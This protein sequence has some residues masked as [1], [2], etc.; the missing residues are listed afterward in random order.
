MEYRSATTAARSEKNLKRAEE[1]GL[2]ALEA[3]ECSPANNSLAPYFLATEVYLQQKNYVK[4]AEM[5]NIAEQ[6]NPNQPL[7]TPFKLG[8]TPVQTIGEGVEAF[9]DQEWTKIYNNAVDLI[10]REK[11]E[12]AKHKIET[13]IL[14]HPQKGENYKTLAAMYIQEEN[15]DMAL[16]TADRGLEEDPKNSMLY[17]MKADILVQSDFSGIP[18]IDEKLKKELILLFKSAKDGNDIANY[19]LI[20]NYNLDITNY[21]LE[22]FKLKLNTISEKNQKQSP[23][24]VKMEN[25]KELYLKAIEFSD[26]PGPIMRKLLFVY[27]DMGDNQKA[28]DYSNELLDKYPN[29]ADLYYNVGV[30]YQR[31]TLELFDPARKLFLETTPESEPATIKGVYD[32][33]KTTRQYAYNSKDYFLQASD[34]ELDKNLSTHEAV[35]EM[36]KLMDQ[37]DEIFIPSIR[38]TAHS[39]GIELN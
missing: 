38:E 8:D 18:V 1:W 23:D 9:R 7:E 10:Q 21:S 12:D 27:I 20:K 35:S 3:P 5:L 15:M 32:S 33:F 26:N 24:L 13:A 30:L 19:D 11:V 22:E 6:R 31:L 36:R 37:I 17:Q 16:S 14:I 28:I 29:D 34:L 2:K 4:M 25:A 39:A